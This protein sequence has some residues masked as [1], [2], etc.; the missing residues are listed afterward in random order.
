MPGVAALCVTREGAGA[1]VLSAAGR[2]LRGLSRGI[3][4]VT[5]T[6][7]NLNASNFELL[8]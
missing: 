6:K 3:T 5:F 4:V 2:Q 7:C 8:Y 1:S